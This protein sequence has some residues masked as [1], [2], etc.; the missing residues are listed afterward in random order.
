MAK[1]VVLGLVL[2]LMTTAGLCAQEKAAGGKAAW[3]TFSPSIETSKAIINAGIGFGFAASGYKMG[4]P[5]ISVSLDFLKLKNMPVMLGVFGGYR[6]QKYAISFILTEVSLTYTEIAFGARATYHANFSPKLDAYAGLTL[7]YAIQS[8]DGDYGDLFP[9][10]S[11]FVYGVNAGGRYFF[12]D[13]IGI[14]AE[15]GYSP[16]QVASVGL[17]LKL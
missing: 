2:V 13:K 8:L 14:Y 10:T 12:S 3:N 4:M 6:T 15:L 1:K 7:G 16:F 9:A 5:P 17:T 11:Y